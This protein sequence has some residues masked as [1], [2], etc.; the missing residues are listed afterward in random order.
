MPS[1]T[2]R[3]TTP[4]Q[5]PREPYEHTEHGVVR[6]DP[7]HWMRRTDSPA[8]LAHLEAERLWY[9]TATGHLNSL[10]ETVRSEMVGRVP[11]TDRSVSWRLHGCSY[12]TA[13]PAG[14]EHHRLLRERN[15]SAEHTLGPEV[16]LDVNDLADDSGYVELGLCLV[17]PD[18]RLL[19]Y[20]VDGTGDEVYELRFRDLETGQD[21]PDVAPRTYYGGAW[22]R[23]SD[24]FFYTVHDDAYRPFQVW[25]HAL[26]TP[27]ADD[28]LVLEEPDER[29]ELNVRATR[30]E[31]LVVL[32]AES[33]DT[34]EVWVL[35]AGSPTSSPRSVGGRR[36]GIEYH[37]EHAVLPDRTDTLLLVTNDDATE[38]RLAR[39][40]VPRDSDQDHTSWTPARAERS[41]ERIKRVDAFA[42]YAVLSYRSETQHR[43]RVLSLDALDGDGFVIASAFAHGTVLI[44]PTTEYD[45][46]AVT[47]EDQSYVDPPVWSGVDLRTGDRTELL[48]RE[49][50]GH[51][52]ASY[53][54]ERRDLPAPDGTPVPVTVVRHRD[55]PLDGTAPALIYG[56]AAYEEVYPDQEWDPAI[57]SLLDRGVV[58]AH[59]HVRGGGERGRR[60]WLEGRMERKQNTFTDYIAVA[61]GLAESG[62]VDGGRIATRGLSA[63]G[64]LQGAVFSQRPDRWRAVVAEVPFVDVVSTMFDASIPLTV[65]EWD[66]WGDPRRRAHFDWML[67]YSPYDN[68]PSG[69]R[70]DLLV[71]G[72]LHDPRVM[73]FEPAKWVARLRETDP[74][75]SPRCL[76][77]VETGAGAHVGPAGRFAHLGYEAEIYAWVLDRLGTSL[78]E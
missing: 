68:P 46:T 64:L 71:T 12:Y 74:G 50:P 44:G 19:A 20:S 9:D 66:E 62:L 58:Y 8:L 32:W 25:R 17:S 35:D 38:F 75:W 48:R 43:L 51:D 60:W 69:P 70:P 61:D 4:P 37:A 21:L 73:V 1:V 6:A 30:S 2:N 14:R 39:C 49:A 45:A 63:G 54:C 10:V 27:V 5:A 13:L 65:T 29:F 55:T 72:A 40:P 33:R 76:F 31:A 77:R 52:P 78:V 41:D 15:D 34:N 23:G 36:P 22:S 57:P 11:A 67:A 42:G 28:V 56:Y 26:S 24:H 53:V 59:A 18:Q 7:Y 3:A 16:L 47:V